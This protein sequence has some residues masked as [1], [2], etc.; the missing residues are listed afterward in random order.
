[1]LSSRLHTSIVTALLLVLTPDVSWASGTCSRSDRAR[2]EKALVPSGIAKHGDCSAIPLEDECSSIFAPNI[3]SI[4]GRAHRNT[5]DVIPKHETLPNSTTGVRFN[6]ES[7]PAALKEDAEMERLT[8]DSVANGAKKNAKSFYAKDDR[9]E[10][11]KPEDVRLEVLSDV[12]ETQVFTGGTGFLA[13]SLTAFAH[14]LPLALEPDHV[15]TVVSFAFAKHVEENAESLRKNFVRHD[16]KKRL[17]LVDANHLRM[18]GGK[19]LGS[20]SS[21]PAKEWEEDVFPEFSRQIQ[22]HIGESTVRKIA[23]EFS[24]T[25][26]AARAAKEITLMSAMKNYFSFGMGTSCGIPSVTLLGSREDWSS[27]RARAEE[28]GELMTTEFSELWMP[29]LLPVLDQFVESYDGNVDHGFWQSMVK[30][31]RGPKPD[32][33]GSEPKI[34]GWLQIL[35]PYLKDGELSGGLRPWQDMYFHGPAPENFPSVISSA[36]V[37]WVYYGSVHNLHF[38]AGITGFVQ[39]SDDGGTLAPLVGWYVTHD[40]HREPDARLLVV[41]AEMKALLRGHAEEARK[42]PLDEGAEWY[43]RFC[44]LHVEGQFIERHARV[45][46]LKRKYDE[47]MKTGDAKH[48][49]KMERLRDKYDRI[50]QAKETV[51]ISADEAIR[52]FLADE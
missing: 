1:M 33:S 20:G 52:A 31:R 46:S 47:L 51:T 39:D 26:P 38:H 16:G 27:L 48:W 35:F 44:A 6:V 18:N 28:L 9:Y 30:V 19:N 15:W 22:E 41:K 21:S 7:V 13:A 32:S 2:M 11:S 43:G 29:I 42:E 8:R 45:A 3:G 24:T 4:T 23:P 10:M 36:P 25:N 40:P 37:D 17:L 34:S 49:T 50:M 12:P 14:H 5:F